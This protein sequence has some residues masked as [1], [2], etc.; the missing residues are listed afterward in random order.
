M[1]RYRTGRTLHRTVYRVVGD[2]ASKSDQFLGIMETPELA[3]QVVVLMNALAASIE[4]LPQ[5]LGA[6]PPGEAA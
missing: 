1:E 6:R 4:A 5:V 3:N 2:E